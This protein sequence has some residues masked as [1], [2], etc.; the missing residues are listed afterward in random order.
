MSEIVLKHLL[1]SLYFILG[2]TEAEICTD[3]CV[4]QFFPSFENFFYLK[5]VS[6]HF[7]EL[8]YE[9]VKYWIYTLIDFN[10][11]LFL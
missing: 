2:L 7:S 5:Y 11:Q 4:H 3:S 1:W 10:N 6:R 9:S 8:N